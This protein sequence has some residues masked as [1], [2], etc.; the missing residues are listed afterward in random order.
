MGRLYDKGVESRECRYRDCWRYEVEYKRGLARACTARIQATP[1]E[2]TTIKNIVRTWFDR[3][4]VHAL[5]SAAAPG[6]A[7]TATK[8]VPES[9][10]QLAY[11]RRC[12]RPMAMRLV[13]RYGW[14]YVAETVCG[15][16]R[17]YEDWET[18]C[19]GI[20]NEVAF[21]G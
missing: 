19:R 6:V 5:F 12:I 8:G 10:R 1:A 2:E 9:D 16:I 13:E 14:R 20:E 11:L 21:E 4:G 7:V 18:L 17:T 15:E 3:R